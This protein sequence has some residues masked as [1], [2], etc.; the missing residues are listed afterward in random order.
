[1][2]DQGKQGSMARVPKA[3][4]Q[5]LWGYSSGNQAGEAGGRGGPGDREATGVGG[6]CRGVLS[7]VRQGGRELWGAE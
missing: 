1:M 3:W 2:R 6:R 5:Q 4:V 7:Q